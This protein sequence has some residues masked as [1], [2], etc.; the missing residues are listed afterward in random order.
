VVVA[1]WAKP[2]P[3]T[4]PVKHRQRHF[5]KIGIKHDYFPP[6][7]AAAMKL[8]LIS[9]YPD[10][11]P[12]PTPL[13]F[14]HGSFSDARVWDVNFLPY[15]AQQG[16]EAHAVS[17]RGHGL[18][19][20]HNRLH[21]WR[22]ADYVAD[23]AKAVETM[24]GPPLL[25]G[26]SMGGM[27]IQKYLEDHAGI[28]GMVLM[29]SVPPQ[30]LMPTNLHMAMRHP[31]LFQQ[32]A[33]FAMLGPSYGSVEM[34]RRLLFSKDMPLS[35]LEEYFDLVQAESQ[36]VAMDMMWFNPLRLKA[37]QLWLPLMVMGAKNDVFVSPAMVEETARF[38]RTE[39]QILPNMAHAMMLEMN[40]REAAEQL[41][42]W[43]KSTIGARTAVAAA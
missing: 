29:A 22:L 3:A 42:G 13:L 40:W 19:E 11:T 23:L 14:V 31:I 21:S 2:D 18:S 38:Y 9:R 1:D 37:G 34:M 6:L 41:L 36:M 24:P 32:M 25:I 26:H 28:A 4:I 7:D 12:K 5:I 10:V 15:F 43:L 16:Y 30:G 20:G 33:M 39:A 35:K 8:D 27:V 17:L